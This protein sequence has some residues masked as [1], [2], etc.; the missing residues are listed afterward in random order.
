MIC[1]SPKEKQ[2]NSALVLHKVN[3][4]AAITDLCSEQTSGGFGQQRHGVSLWCKGKFL[5]SGVVC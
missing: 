5:N 4:H 1:V 2:I 3:Y